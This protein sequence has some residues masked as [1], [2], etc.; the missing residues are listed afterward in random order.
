MSQT[1]K[2]PV[3]LRS[4]RQT[5][6]GRFCHGGGGGVLRRSPR[7][8][9]GALSRAAAGGR[10]DGEAAEQ[11]VHGGEQGLEEADGAEGGG[12]V[13]GEVD[14]V[15]VGAGGD[16]LGRFGLVHRAGD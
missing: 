15:G 6:P 11:Q 9:A 7:A 3:T 10:G 5:L 14:L 16:E 1:S 4:E 8:G 13:R 12:P 2:R